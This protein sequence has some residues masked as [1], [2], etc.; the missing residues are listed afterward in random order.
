[1]STTH[2]ATN[3]DEPISEEERSELQRV[4]AQPRGWRRLS[5]INNTV[6][7]RYY[8]L[9]ALGFLFAGGVLAL[10]MRLQLAVPDNNLFSPDTYNQL[11]TMHGTTMMFLFAVPAVE[12]VAVYMMPQMLGARDLPFPRLSAFGYWCY[13]FGGTIAFSSLFFGIAPDGG[14]FMYTPLSSGEYSPGVNADVWLLGIGF[15]EI[16]AITAAVEIIVGLLRTRAPGMSINRVPLLGW[17]VF[18]TAA[19]IL[20]GFPPMLLGDTLLELQRALDLPFFD[21]NRGGDPL[22]WQHLFW[23]FGHPEV[24]IIFLP[25]AGIVSMILPTFAQRPFVGYSWAVLGAM[26]VGFLSFAL[27]VHH[28]FTTG[29]PHVSLSFFSAA[30]MMVVIPNAIQFFCWI[31]TL[32]LGKPVFKLPMLYLVGFFSVFLIGGLT[33]VMVAV[34]PFDWQAH[35]TYFIVAHLHYVLIGGMVFPLL[36]GIVYWLPAATGRM[37]DERLGKWAFWMLF[38]GF[39]VAFLPMHWTGLIG[40]PRRIYTYGADMGWN[41]LNLTSTGGAL[42]LG[43]GFVVFAYAVLHAAR[44]GRKAEHNPWN[45][46]TLE[47]A[48]GLP[49][50]N[51]GFTSVPVVHTRYPVWEQPEL[52]KEIREGR[53]H[54]AHAASGRRETIV[55][56]AV[57]AKP[58]YVLQ[59]PHPTYIPMVTAAIV[60]ICFL[61]LIFKAYALAVVTAVMTLLMVYLWVWRTPAAVGETVD[62]GHGI[63]L[64]AYVSGRRS[65]QYSGVVVSL[66]FDAVAYAALVFSYL[67]LFTVRGLP[68]PPAGYPLDNLMSAGI[69]A[70]LAI[71]L[72]LTGVLGARQ[73][74]ANRRGLTGLA[75]V[76]LLALQAGTFAALL[77]WMR[78]ISA[79]ADAYGATLWTLA[80]YAMTH[81][82]VSALMVIYVLAALAA[83]RLSAARPLALE[84]TLLVNRFSALLVL[85]TLALVAFFPRLIGH[86]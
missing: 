31:A 46:G 63:T 53:H 59:L 86:G 49:M 3:P 35:D 21:A 72:L 19:M 71:A 75:L 78:P 22:L 77:A 17:Y 50:R 26:G 9:T 42:L 34:L 60:T 74:R 12:A 36:A 10:L 62:I 52:S 44:H 80:G 64:P 4:W 38:T 47:W 32:W 73:L 84:N 48:E 2:A 56:S 41:A 27:W 82:V 23:M 6:I 67:Y 20:F 55:T 1:M 33:G 61:A 65:V 39:N 70:L 57:D 16:S 25:A 7:G 5:E 68:W 37:M 58:D 69:P 43:A 14:W 29:L 30:S 8:L 11:F 76:V 66:T 28:M 83:G 79:N 24:Y 54:L 40:M 85:V 81:V 15:I 18:V 45:A 51:H 13:L